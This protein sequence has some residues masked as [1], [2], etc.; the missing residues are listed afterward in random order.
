MDIYIY[1][2]RKEGLWKGKPLHTVSLRVCYFPQP[3]FTVHGYLTHPILAQEGCAHFIHARA[4]SIL[5][6]YLS[7]GFCLHLYK[8]H[9]A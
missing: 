5:K 6:R 9:F 4:D 2:H 7:Q 1:K 8:R 3:L